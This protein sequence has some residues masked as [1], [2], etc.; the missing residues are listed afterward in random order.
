MVLGVNRPDANAKMIFR[1]ISALNGFCKSKPTPPKPSCDQ[2][3]G[4]E[5]SIR[6]ISATWSSTGKLSIVL[7][8]WSNSCRR[9]SL[10]TGSSILSQSTY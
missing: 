8:S 1:I 3:C 7:E 9:I 2:A 6:S 4:I 5:S 10:F